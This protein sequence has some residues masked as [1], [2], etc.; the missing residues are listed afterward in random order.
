MN[1]LIIYFI[2]INVS[3]FSVYGIDK[4]LAVKDKR[5][6][7]EYS[8]LL[9]SFLGGSMG[10]FVAMLLFRHKIKKISYMMKYIVIV[11]LQ[12]VAIWYIYQNNIN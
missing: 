5:R 12:I 10:A 11:I 3:A 8:L 2:F 7:S 9:L 4:Y 1:Y 6:L